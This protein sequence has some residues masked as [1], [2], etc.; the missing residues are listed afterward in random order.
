MKLSDSN[1]SN[2]KK[3]QVVIFQQS[4][5]PMELKVL[6]LQTNEKRGGFWQNITGGVEK[7]DSSTLDAAKREVLE[8]TGLAPEHFFSLD[9]TYRFT[10]RWNTNVEEFVFYAICKTN[11]NDPLDIVIDPKEHQSFKWLPP[12]NISE[13]DYE[14]K[15]NYEAFIASYRKIENV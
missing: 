7:I 5:N 12:K 2:R 15:N 11:T 9:V 6:L 3:V 10:D 8:E 14:F 4:Q 1:N 13:K